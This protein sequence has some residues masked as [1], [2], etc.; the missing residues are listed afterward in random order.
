MEQ[1]KLNKVTSN[2]KLLLFGALGALALFLC[3]PRNTVIISVG[4]L[5]VNKK[6]EA[7]K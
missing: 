4:N 6:D 2:K 1:S 5:N 3:I 7:A